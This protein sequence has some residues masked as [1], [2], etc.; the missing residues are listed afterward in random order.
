MG[1]ALKRAVVCLNAS[2][3]M[4]FFAGTL[5]AFFGPLPCAILCIAAFMLMYLAGWKLEKKVDSIRDQL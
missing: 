4:T 5:G 1:R 3:T 2:L